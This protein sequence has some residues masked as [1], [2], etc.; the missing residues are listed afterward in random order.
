ME[1]L[2]IIVTL[3]AVAVDVNCKYE[4]K[5][6][7]V[8]FRHGDRTPD[9]LYPHLPYSAK[10]FYPFGIGGLTNDGKV[11]AFEFGEFLRKKYDSFLGTTYVSDDVQSLSSNFERTKM[12]LQLVLAGLY[13]PNT[14]QKW[15]K[16]LNWQPIP[17]NY[18]DRSKD[19]M[20]QRRHICS[21]YLDERKRILQSPKLSP[22][23]SSYQNLMKNLTILTGRNMTDLEDLYSLY[24]NFVA[25]ERM[26]FSLPNWTA[27][28]YPKGKLYDA[29][30]L[31]L[32]IQNYNN[33]IKRIHGGGFVRTII[34]NMKSVKIQSDNVYPKLNL[35]SGHD[36]NV[37]GLLSSL[38]LVEPHLPEFTSAVIVELLSFE[39]KY[40]VKIW[41]YRGTSSN[42]TELNISNC[43]SPCS[44]NVFIGAAKIVTPSEEEFKCI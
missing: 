4:I 2:L 6:I 20:F 26:G 35:Y 40:Y 18:N 8:I 7:N 17:T 3:G 5:Q 23:L 36:I 16:D 39:S 12:T 13:P 38:N 42:L 11:R 31:N 21:K 24:A 41:Y 22:I 19:N 15:K 14:N 32:K 44:L 43:P 27:N 1:L 33:L 29:M 28:I 25:L 37:L 10:D 30:I 9:I 34:E